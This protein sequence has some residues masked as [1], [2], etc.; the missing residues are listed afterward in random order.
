MLLYLLFMNNIIPVV[1]LP[2]LKR[3]Q[4]SSLTLGTNMY[5]KKKFNV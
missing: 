2:T 1:L 4:D 5:E 3:L